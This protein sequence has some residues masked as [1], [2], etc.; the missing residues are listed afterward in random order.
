MSAML[1]AILLRWHFAPRDRERSEVLFASAVLPFVCSALCMC[2]IDWLAGA[3]PVKYDYYLFRADGVLGFQPSFVMGRL[4]YHHPFVMVSAGLAY[5][6]LPAALFSVFAV[7]LYRSE[8]SE[9]L[10]VARTLILNLV[11][12]VPIYALLPACG[13]R[14]TFPRSF[15]DVTPHHIHPHPA[16]L[17]GPPNAFPSVHTSSALLIFWFLRKWPAGRVLGLA[18][19]VLTIVATLGSGEHWFIDLLAAVP[20]TLLVYRYSANPWRFK[21]SLPAISAATFEEAI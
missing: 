4:F 18:F 11:A 3:L 14:N 7:H 8:L 15:P 21:R 5:N 10:R 9:T 20:Y 17:A 6:L 13:P 1:L 16:V 19:L 12:A 2:V